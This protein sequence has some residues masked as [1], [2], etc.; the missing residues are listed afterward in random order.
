MLL[1]QPGHIR[2]DYGKGDDLLIVAD[3]DQAALDLNER[4]YQQLR[5]ERSLAVVPGVKQLFEEPA[6]IEQVAGMAASWFHTHM[7]EVEPA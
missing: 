2:F 6:G 4:A 1:K 3:G 7:V 5:C